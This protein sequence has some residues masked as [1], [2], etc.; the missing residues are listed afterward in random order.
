MNKQQAYQILREKIDI[1]NAALNEARAFADEHGLVMSHKD[2]TKVI[3]AN[4]RK[5][6]PGDYDEDEED[7][8]DE[9]PYIDGLLTVR[10][11]EPQRVKNWDDERAIMN[12]EDGFDYGW[13]PSSLRC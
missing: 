10:T 3:R 12:A 1:A 7:Y 4:D 13:I 6:Y 9:G 5:L 2:N 11:I 8:S